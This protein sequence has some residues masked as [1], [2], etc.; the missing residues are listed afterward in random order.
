MAGLSRATWIA[1]GLLACGGPQTDRPETTG[2]G[3]STEL[4]TSEQGPRLNPH[5]PRH[6]LEP[7]PPCGPLAFATTI[8]TVNAEVTDIVPHPDGGVVVAVEFGGSIR[9]FEGEPEERLL[10][11]WG[12][13]DAFIGR[14]ASDGTLLWAEQVGGSDIE[15]DLVIAVRDDGVV[16]AAGRSGVASPKFNVGEPDEFRPDWIDSQHMW[17][18]GYADD[19]ALLWYGV[20]GSPWGL[21]V[22]DAAFST[23]G[24]PLLMGEYSSTLVFHDGTQALPASTPAAEVENWE[25]GF[26]IRLDDA[27]G[28]YAQLVQLSVQGSGLGQE[29]LAILDGGGFAAAW[30][31]AAEATLNPGT[32]EAI[33]VPALD[34]PFGDLILVG[35]DATGTATWHRRNGVVGNG[36]APDGLIRAG[37]ALLLGGFLYDDPM[38]F[39]IGGSAPLELSGSGTFVATVDADGKPVQGLDLQAGLIPVGVAYDPAK[40]RC[41]TFGMQGG[42]QI[43][44]GG[45]ESFD[46]GPVSDPV[47]A[48]WESWGAFHCAWRLDATGATFSKAQAVA[49]DS[50]G[51]VWVGGFYNG[52]LLIEE[53]E[54]WGTTLTGA[55]DT[56]AFLARFLLEEPQSTNSTKKTEQR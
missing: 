40:G 8:D 2:S 4:P 3:A 46:A 41:A 11:A 24:A 27:S 13:T 44:G 30:D 17:W 52:D 56:S 23:S 31:I 15:R 12:V 32:P 36:N 10:D 45:E 29:G 1:F 38:V 21:S 42:T 22:N 6:D 54:P 47:L 49:F 43:F 20:G 9:I 25:D 14:Y 33:T 51:G 53:H 48:T 16:L 34:A 19:G 26:V 39:D 55:G 18:A 7:I 5:L 28:Q 37:D 35:Y 50:E